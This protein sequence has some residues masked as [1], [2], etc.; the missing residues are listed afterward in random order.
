MQKDLKET[1]V[2]RLAIAS[3]KNDKELARKILNEYPNKAVLLRGAIGVILTM[4]YETADEE[5]SPEDILDQ[6]LMEYTL[7]NM[8]LENG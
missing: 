4:V 8:D 3:Q 5:N 7:T 2:L 6:M 1:E